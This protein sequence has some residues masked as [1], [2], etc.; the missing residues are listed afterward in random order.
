MTFFSERPEANIFISQ[1]PW[2]SRA[3]K[4]AVASR[5]SVWAEK[6]R[7]RIDITKKIRSVNAL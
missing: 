5:F 4:M 6:R 3:N 1:A 7:N 2:T